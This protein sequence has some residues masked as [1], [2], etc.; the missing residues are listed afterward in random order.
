MDVFIEQ[1]VSIKKTAKTYMTY[2][3][4]VFL[5]LIILL[6]TYLFLTIFFIPIFALVVFG[7]YKLCVRL[8]I[9]Y[10]YIVT[11]TTMDIDKIIAKSSRKRVISFDITS[12]QRIEKYTGV[13]P[14]GTEKDCFF[15]CNKN[16][17]GAFVVYYKGGGKQQE[18]FVFA[19]NELVRE[20]I[21]GILPRYIGENL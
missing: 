20:S 14:K 6:T 4:I 9:E 13:L 15:A 7:A 11:N 21:K 17:Q 2:F 19:P 1:I 12:I 5:A 18:S 8:N 16:E 10:E 3:A